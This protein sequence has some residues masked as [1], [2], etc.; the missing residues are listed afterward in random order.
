MQQEKWP[1]YYP[2]CLQLWDEH[3]KE[4][5]EDAKRMPLN[6][7]VEQYEFSDKAGSLQIVTARENKILIG[8]C[9]FFISKSIISKEILCGTQN[10]FFVTK[11]KRN[12]EAGLGMFRESISIMREKGVQNIYPHHYLRGDSLRLGSFFE[13]L[14]AKELMHEY[15]LWI[16]R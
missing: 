12:S 4:I 8:Y 6:P 7:D 13:R 1:A 14:G 2:D 9:L 16:G 11:H 3:N 5:G 15:S 10:I